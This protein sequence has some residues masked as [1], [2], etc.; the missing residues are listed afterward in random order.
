[1]LYRFCKIIKHFTSSLSL[2]VSQKY[3]VNAPMCVLKASR[4]MKM[5]TSNASLWFAYNVAEM[6]QQNGNVLFPFTSYIPLDS[7]LE[8]ILVV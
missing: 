1:M 8:G 3:K 4:L 7:Q 5:Y 6:Q 2:S